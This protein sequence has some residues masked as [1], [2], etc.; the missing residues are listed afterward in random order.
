[1]IVGV[2]CKRYWRCDSVY[3]FEIEKGLAMVL[4]NAGRKLRLHLLSYYFALELGAKYGWVPEPMISG[5][6]IEAAPGS[7]DHEYG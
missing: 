5:E 1:M 7:F 3:E 4:R 2:V 6:H